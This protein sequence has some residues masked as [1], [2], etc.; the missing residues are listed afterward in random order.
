MYLIRNTNIIN[1]IKNLC[2]QK[3]QK[4]EPLFFFFFFL[5]IQKVELDLTQ[6]NGKVQNIVL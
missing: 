3:I 1:K 2:T 4:V 6:P 5:R